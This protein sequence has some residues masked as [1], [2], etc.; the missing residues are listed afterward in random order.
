MK[1]SQGV[2]NR[3]TYDSVLNYMCTCATYVK[4]YTCKI[5]PMI[6]ITQTKI[7]INF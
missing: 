5:F 2:K 6:F 4:F 3:I 7:V 1:F